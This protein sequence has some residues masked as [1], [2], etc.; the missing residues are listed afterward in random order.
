MEKQQLFEIL[1]KAKALQEFVDACAEEMGNP[2]WIMDVAYRTIAQSREPDSSK[3]LTDFTDGNTMERVN[4]WVESGLLKKVSGNRTPVRLYDD[5]IGENVVIMDIFSE[6]TSI[7][8]L[9]IV[10]YQDITDEEVIAISNAASVYLRMQTSIS[11]ST[12]EQGL[13]LLLQDSPEAESTGYKILSSAGYMGKPPYHIAKVETTARER[14]SILSAF[15]LDVRNQDPSIIGGIIGNQCVILTADGHEIPRSLIKK[16]IRVGYSLPFESIRSIRDY[17]IQA[18]A[19]VR[20]GGGKIEYFAE[21]YDEYIGACMRREV[22]DTWSFIIPE[23]RA[24]IRYDDE[25]NTDYYDTLKQY[26][27]LTC[28]KQKTAD[29]MGLHLNTVKYRINQL[30]KNFGIDF[31]K[32]DAIVGSIYAKEASD[33]DE[34]AWEK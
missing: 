6:R 5:S 13:A 4:G 30:E 32:L 16:S 3:F 10:I 33:S 21:H 9:T 22:R 7:G 12:M 1:I 8:K 2:F 24:V 25:Y 27:H 28:S 31:T 18:D 15:V 20:M 14:S 26:V 19:A 11:G 23:V 34:T 17:W 29:A